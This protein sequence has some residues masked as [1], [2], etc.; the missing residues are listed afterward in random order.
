MT[1]KMTMVFMICIMFLLVTG[2][3]GVPKWT[4][5]RADIY[6]LPSSEAS[7]IAVAE[8][9]VDLLKIAEEGEFSKIYC[10]ET[11][12]WAFIRTSVLVDT[13]PYSMPLPTYIDNTNTSQMIR[14]GDSRISQMYQAIGE[15]ERAKSSWIASPGSGYP[16]FLSTAVPM[17]DAMDI[18][19]KTIV[20]QLGVNDILYRGSDYSRNQYSLFYNT[21]AMEWVNRGAKVYFD[22]V[23]PIRKDQASS[24]VILGTPEDSDFTA[25]NDYIR[26]SLPDGIACISYNEAKAAGQ[27]VPIETVDGVHFTQM[28]YQCIYQYE[29]QHY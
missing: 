8:A 5:V 1:K 28:V 16:W 23:W 15:E 22:E 25:Y 9:G 4:S 27:V 29:A 6:E 11:G 12:S 20:I 7:V 3:L 18:N 21:K 26:K 2:F 13:R 19:G 17:I 10:R 14:V 24:Q